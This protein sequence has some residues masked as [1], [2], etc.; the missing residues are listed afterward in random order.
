MN[1]DD[2]YSTLNQLFFLRKYAECGELKFLF[3]QLLVAQE[4]TD[5]SHIRDTREPQ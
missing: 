1:Q 2:I 5:K 3:S 4:T